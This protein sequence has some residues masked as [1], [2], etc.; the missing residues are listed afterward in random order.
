M[1]GTGGLIAKNLLGDPAE[2][3]V[4]V[5]GGAFAQLKP[6]RRLIE[7][8]ISTQ[9]QFPEILEFLRLFAGVDRASAV[10][11]E[12]I[13]NLTSRLELVTRPAE[14][15]KVAQLGRSTV[16]MINLSC[17]L[18]IAV[19][20]STVVLRQYNLANLIAQSRSS[21]SQIKSEEIDHIIKDDL[22]GHPVGTSS[23]TYHLPN[24]A[25]L[26][27]L[28]ATVIRA[29]ASMPFSYLGRVKWLKTA[30][31]QP[32]LPLALHGHRTRL[33][34]HNRTKRLHRDDQYNCVQPGISA[35][36]SPVS[37]KRY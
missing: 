13:R 37:H 27:G 23:V 5:F 14:S 20:T 1:S 32:D 24:I 12:V 15:A 10:A 36:T 9:C 31:A 34:S 17:W 28:H 6:L 8:L 11:G 25:D 7:R 30:N 4:T 33:L 3:G 16:D 26:F 35:T 18:I 2:P 29:E 19:D 21:I 22:S